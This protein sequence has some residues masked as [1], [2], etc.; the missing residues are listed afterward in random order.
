MTQLDKLDIKLTGDFNSDS[1]TTNGKKLDFFAG[2][3]NLKLHVHQPTRI[4][5]INGSIID[6][7]ITTTHV[8]M[9]NLYVL[10]PLATSDHYR[11]VLH[12]LFGF[13][14]EQTGIV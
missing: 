11:P 5:Y 8:N 6:Q 13:T 9:N 2:C 7:F 14:L 12:V 3:Y 4:T 10:P 1:Q